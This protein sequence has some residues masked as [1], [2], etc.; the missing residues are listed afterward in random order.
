M[1]RSSSTTR[2]VAMDDILPN[3]RCR[4]CAGELPGAN[5][6]AISTSSASAIH[7]RWPQ[8]ALRQQPNSPE[9]VRALSKEIIMRRTLAVAGII[10]A[11]LTATALAMAPAFAANGPLTTANP[12]G[13]ATCPL[14]GTAPT[15]TGMGMNGMGTTGLGQGYG[16]GNGAETVAETAAEWVAAWVPDPGGRV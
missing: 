3:N 6:H 11:G 13:T 12:D 5:L 9:R 1:S 10:A 4:G 16:R 2:T 8:W 15:G 7:M 14:T